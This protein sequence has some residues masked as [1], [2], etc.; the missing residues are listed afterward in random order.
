MNTFPRS[1]SFTRAFGISVRCQ[2]IASSTKKQAKHKIVIVGGGSGGC[3]MAN[4]LCSHVDMDQVAVIEPSTTHYYQPLFTLVGAGIKPLKEAHRPLQ[5]VLTQKAKLYQDR[6]THI[7]PKDSYVV[8][9]NGDKISYDYLILALGMDLRFDKVSLVMVTACLGFHKFVGCLLDVSRS[10]S[11]MEKEPLPG[12][13]ESLI[14][15]KTTS[16][17]QPISSKQKFNNQNH[18]HP[19]ITQKKKISSNKKTSNTNKHKQSK[20]QKKSTKTKKQ[21]H[22]PLQQQTTQES[23]IFRKHTITTSKEKSHQ[24]NT[25]FKKIHQQIKQKTNNNHIQNKKPSNIVNTFKKITKQNKLYKLL[26]TQSPK[27]SISNTNITDKSK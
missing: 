3:A 24:K 7:E 22:T 17:K 21:S 12:H 14:Q 15:T 9:S 20:P 10:K 19:K 5:E 6:V 27:N 13:I 4:R 18:K 11:N 1:I 2:S 16:K 25:L 8:L 26:Q 23:N